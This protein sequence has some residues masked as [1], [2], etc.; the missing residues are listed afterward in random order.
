MWISIVRRG[1]KY[2]THVSGA[3][4][5]LGS[6]SACVSFRALELQSS[7]IDNDKHVQFLIGKIVPK[8]PSPQVQGLGTGHAQATHVASWCAAG[9]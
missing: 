6:P 2:P 9:G 3:P 4:V 8:G 1:E 5:L 7:K